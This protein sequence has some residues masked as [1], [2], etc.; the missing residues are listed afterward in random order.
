MKSNRIAVTSPS[1]SENRELRERLLAEFPNAYFN[2]SHQPLTASLL[3]E[4]LKGAAGA[5]IGLDKI[6]SEV[7]EATPTLRYISKYGVGLDNIDFES[8]AKYGVRVG[9]SQGVN[10]RSVAEHV[11]AKSLLLTH[12]FHQVNRSMTAGLWKK[13]GGRQLSSCCFG[14]IGLGNVGKEVYH[15]LRPLVSKIVYF[16]ISRQIEFEREHMIEYVDFS[17]LVGCCD[18]ISL[19]AS[20]NPSSKGMVNSAT[21]RSMQQGTILINTARSDLVKFCDLRD[22]IFNGNTL[23]AYGVDVFPNEPFTD[24]EFL[25][26]PKVYATAHIAG[27]TQEA[28]LEMGNAAISTLS[29]FFDT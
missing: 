28:V 7:L 12:N 8:C 9:F 22:E 17:K 24:I 27:N 3:Q 10:K 20:L 1:F 18:V 16:D 6:T 21:I 19:N 13:K 5:V 29:R 14:I 4:F 15:L 2:D 11:L 23:A 26:N 25:S